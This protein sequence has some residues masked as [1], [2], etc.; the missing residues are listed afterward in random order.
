[1]IA[2]KSDFRNL[3][4]STP[5]FE[6]NGFIVLK[7]NIFSNFICL[8]DLI[9]SAIEQNSGFFFIFRYK[10]ILNY[11]FIWNSTP[12]EFDSG[13]SIYIVS[14]TFDFI[15]IQAITINRWLFWWYIF[16][17]LGTQAFLS[18]TASFR[19]MY[20]CV[21]NIWS[22]SLRLDYKILKGPSAVQLKRIVQSIV[23]SIVKWIKFMVWCMYGVSIWTLESNRD[24]HYYALANYIS[25][26]LSYSVLHMKWGQSIIIE[27]YILSSAV[28][29]K[30][31][32]FHFPQREKPKFFI[33]L[34]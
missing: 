18:P 22:I 3:K 29:K 20:M 25:S 32:A 34:N 31:W 26:K 11:P 21:S 14:V 2:K 19:F 1:M 16:G 27:F 15:Q 28:S 30:P 17:Y 24:K 4:V 13:I 6:F 8:S 23:L 5:V 12:F 33:N 9:G 7:M 10:H